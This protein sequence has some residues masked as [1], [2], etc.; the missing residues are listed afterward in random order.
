VLELAVRDMVITI[1]KD[2]MLEVTQLLD[3]SV[4][5]VDTRWYKKRLLRRE[6]F[7]PYH[8]EA[9]L[10][11]T[12]ILRVGG[13]GGCRKIILSPLSHFWIALYCQKPGHIVNYNELW[14]LHSLGHGTYWI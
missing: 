4:S 7:G 3:N 12:P 2:A 6:D 14:Y 9:L 1:L 8:V 11:I 5:I 10:H 13:G